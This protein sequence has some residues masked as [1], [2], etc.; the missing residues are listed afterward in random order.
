VL[1]YEKMLDETGREMH[2]SW[3]NMITAGEAFQRMGADVMRWQY[4]MQPPNQNLLFGFGP[5]QEIHRKLLTVWNSAAFFIQYANVA[6]FQPDL[7]DLD[8]GV[9]AKH[10][11][12]RWLR[13]STAQL[14]TQ[15]TEASDGFLT[16][17]VLR[18]FESFVEDVSTWY[19]RR[20]R[21]RFWNGEEAA[22]RSLWSALVQGIRVISPVM[23]F[24]AEHLWQRLV[25]GPVAGAPASVVLAEWP[26]SVPVEDALL[27]RI[28]TVRKVVDL[29][30][31][32]RVSAQFKLRRPLRLLIVDGVEGI[33]E[34]LDQIADE[35]RV[36]EIRVGTIETTQL[37]VRPN[38]P[39]VGRKL[40]SA[41]P[42]IRK[43][44]DAGDYVLHSDGRVEVAGHMLA[45]DEVL[46]DRL[47]KQGWAVASEDG[48]TVAYDTT[49][50][51]TLRREARVYELIHQVNAMRRNAGLAI[52]DRI[53]LTLP[54]TD[55]DLLDFREWIET[56]TLATT[57]GTGDTLSLT[58]TATPR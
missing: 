2:G 52:T 34:Y 49:L 56:E 13:A 50:D 20:S 25:V 45:P 51:D 54:T 27:A 58:R 53:A 33:D 12:D 19:I 6:D 14:V 10:P 35:L 55:A 42:V 29:G 57:I 3:G 9:R 1:G 40:G 26:A 21:R 41:V 5:G 31:R 17:N 8:D 38:L 15:V 36:K 44:L 11:M 24:L 48:I 23:P 18:S 39:V 47:E 46:V 37:R 4:C 16:V 32:A 28:A 30:R 7:A 22:L 43:A